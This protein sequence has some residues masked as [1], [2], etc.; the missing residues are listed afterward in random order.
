[1]LKSLLLA[2]TILAFTA[3]AYAQQQDAKE[4][5]GTWK[6]VSLKT[7]SADGK[8]ST[9]PL[10]DKP[11]G[12]VTITPNRMWLL[13]IDGTRKAPAT[14]APTDAEQIAMM[15]TN[16]TWTGT[17]KTSEQTP[18]GIKVDAKVDM[19]VNQSLAN[20]P[21]IYFMKVVGG[22]LNVKSTPIVIPMTGEKAVV[23]YEMVK[24]D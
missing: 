4:L 20:T 1:M 18:D 13:F 19:A 10:G 24:A 16:A 11:E 17:Y 3:P 8:M 22:K 12:Y 9:G 21:R 23:Q 7:V 15:K 5:L 2:A 14:A 6:L